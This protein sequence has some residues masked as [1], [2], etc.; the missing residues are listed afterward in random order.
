[1]N[2]SINGTKIA[3]NRLVYDFKR[4][5]L[6]LKGSTPQFKLIGQV[7]L[8]NLFEFSINHEKQVLKGRCLYNQCPSRIGHELV[9]LSNNHS[10]TK[11]GQ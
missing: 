1:M 10:L 6:L 7:G 3:V 4:R 9:K 8:N 2:L 11:F 5:V